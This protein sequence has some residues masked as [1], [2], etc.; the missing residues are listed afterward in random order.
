MVDDTT[1]GT[2]VLGLDG[3]ALRTA[4]LVEGEVWLHAE[5]TAVRTG[6][7]DCGVMASSHDRRTVHLRDMAV[8]GRPCRLVWAKRIWR[9]REP[10]CPRATWTEQRADVAPARRVLTIRAA[11]DICLQVGRLGRP[12]AHLADDYGVGWETANQ[13]VLDHA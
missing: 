10:A 12:V 1:L 8:T 4:E 13:A 3:F 9:C 2:V 7:P 6:C 5:T 11:Q